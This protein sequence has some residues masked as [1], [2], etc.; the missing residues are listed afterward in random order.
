LRQS[1]RARASFQQGRRSPT[2]QPTE[3]EQA[4]VRGGDRF[5]LARAPLKEQIPGR[6]GKQNPPDADE[7]QMQLIGMLDSPYVRRVAVALI[8]AEVPFTHRPIS[9]FRHIDEFSKLNALLKAPTL[10]TDE[11]TALMDSNVILDYLAGAYPPVAAL[12]PP[13]AS[14]RLRAL[15]STGI[16][17]T[18]M[19]KAVQRHYERALRPPDKRHQPWIDRVMSQL[20]AGLAALD[21]ELPTSGWIGGEL[22]HGDIAVACAFGFVRGMLSDVADTSRYPNLAGFCERAEAL[23]A[24]RDAPAED[25]ATAQAGLAD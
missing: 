14:R 13:A 4:S 1:A 10:V 22:G 16:A 23:P 5:L 9:L 15:R 21:A 8:A 17:L 19:E 20:T 12:T 24:F 3:T 2:E 11:G 7:D 25:G 6:A 18:V